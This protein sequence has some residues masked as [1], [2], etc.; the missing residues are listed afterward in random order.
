MTDETI[1]KLAA[2]VLQARRE[3]SLSLA[4]VDLALA[5]TEAGYLRR[6]SNG[7]LGTITNKAMLRHELYPTFE[8]LYISLRNED[9]RGIAN[10]R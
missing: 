4:E 6:P 10:L 7:F 2:H 9:G 1:A 3:S 8:P 5:L